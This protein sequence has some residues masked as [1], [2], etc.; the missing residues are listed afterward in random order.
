MNTIAITVMITL[1]V[2]L[3]T[4]IK[5]QRGNYLRNKQFKFP[6]SAMASSIFAVAVASFIHPIFGLGLAIL[7]AMYQIA[8]LW[9]IEKLINERDNVRRTVGSVDPTDIVHK[10]SEDY[11]EHEYTIMS[12]V[13]TPK[14]HSDLQI[15][16]VIMLRRKQLE[17]LEQ[18]QLLDY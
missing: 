8:S 16:Q 9:L 3:F 15:A 7:F 6:L 1:L 18:Y 11:M 14:P 4:Y 10:L 17:I 5:T 13:N 2:L 12:I